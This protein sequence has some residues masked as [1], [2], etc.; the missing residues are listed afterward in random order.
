MH[1]KEMPRLCKLSLN[2]NLTEDFIQHAQHYQTEQIRTLEINTST[3]NL[4]YIIE[5][6]IRLFPRIERLSISTIYLRKDIIRLIDGFEHLSNASFVIQSSLSQIDLKWFNKPELSI[7]GV[8]RLT[9]G[10][11]TCEFHRL[12]MTDSD[13]QMNLWIG[14]QVNSFFYYFHLVKCL[15]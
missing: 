6:F 9:S 15:I 2:G 7:R 3:K 12:M 8:R 11:F 13:Y 5:G 14:E 10:T 4:S 1:L